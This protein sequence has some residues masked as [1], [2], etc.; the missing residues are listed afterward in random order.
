MVLVISKFIQF[1]VLLINLSQCV[2]LSR[3]K[4]TF[5]PFNNIICL[6]IQALFTI[7]LAYPKH[8]INR[9]FRSQFNNTE[10]S[11]SSLVERVPRLTASC[12]DFARASSEIKVARRLNTLTLTRHTQLLQVLEI[13]QLM[14]TCIR[15]GHYEEALQ[16][17]AYVK[18]LAGKHGEI[19]VVA[20]SSQFDFIFIRCNLGYLDF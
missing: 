20:V 6:N 3:N 8:Q 2:P 17:A 16:L 14:E 19:P 11:L 10:T 1:F 5:K 4:R 12:E 9:C 18:R 13:P 7:C 15:D